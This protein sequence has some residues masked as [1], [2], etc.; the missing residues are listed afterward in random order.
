MASPVGSPDDARSSAD[1]ELGTHLFQVLNRALDEA[2]TRLHVDYT[3]AAR[4]LGIPELWLRQRISAL[5]HR[6]LGK[7]VRFTRA[8]LE[9]IS[10]MHSIHPDTGALMHV[11]AARSESLADLKPATRARRR[12]A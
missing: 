8:D 1:A 12:A 7:W 11:A 2:D 10:E 3:E 4:R 6:K 9:L 5:P